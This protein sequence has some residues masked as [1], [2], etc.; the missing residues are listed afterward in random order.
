MVLSALFLYL[1]GVLTG[2]FVG[3]LVASDAEEKV[4]NA[5]EELSNKYEK[6]FYDVITLISDENQCDYL[7]HRID[8]LSDELGRITKMLPERLEVSSAPQTIL[9]KY[10]KLNIRAFLLANVIGKKCP[11]G[12]TPVI[13]IYRHGDLNAGLFVD[14]LKE[15]FRIR[16]FVTD[17]DTFREILHTKVDPPALY[18]CGRI[19]NISEANEV[20]GQCLKK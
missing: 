19:V 1:S 9:N 20:I 5:I 12:W 13:Y 16:V 3:K 15:E 2:S 11:L 4:E 6:F 7:R 17:A 14:K 10:H 8:E 18:F